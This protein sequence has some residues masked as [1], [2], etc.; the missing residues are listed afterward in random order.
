MQQMTLQ[1]YEYRKNY[2][3][4]H[5]EPQVAQ[6]V[7]GPWRHIYFI[8]SLCCL[9]SEPSV[10]IGPGPRPRSRI[11]RTGELSAS[12][13]WKVSRYA[14][15]QPLSES[16]TSSSPTSTTHTPVTIPHWNPRSLIIRLL[17]VHIKRTPSRPSAHKL[18]TTSSLIDM[19]YSPA[20]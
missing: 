20:R 4:L 11:T 5:L 6:R 3:L 12:R 2:R 9:D 13:I 16:L 7:L 15:P 19:S 1:G 17:M 8:Y 14:A 10:S 18:Q